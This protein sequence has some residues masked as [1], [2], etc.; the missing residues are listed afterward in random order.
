M[1]AHV[2]LCHVIS[3]T[4]RSHKVV[5]QIY[6]KISIFDSI[7]EQYIA[8]LIFCPTSKHDLSLHYILVYMVQKIKVSPPSLVLLSMF[9]GCMKESKH[10][11]ILKDG[12]LKPCVVDITFIT[13]LGISKREIFKPE[14]N[15][16]AEMFAKLQQKKSLPSFFFISLPLY[17]NN[18]I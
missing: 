10:S 13:R 2:A 8:A 14:A 3:A 9:D 5:N 1:S 16:N 7:R 4:V 12:H 17:S 6:M 15:E 11:F 18:E